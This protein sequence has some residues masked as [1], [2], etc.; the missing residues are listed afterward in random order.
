MTNNTDRSEQMGSTAKEVARDRLLIELSRHLTR[1]G[2]PHVGLRLS[3]AADTLEALSTPSSPPAQAAPVSGEGVTD[4]QLR[5]ILDT[6]LHSEGAINRAIVDGDD[7]VFVAYD[8]AIAAMR[9]ML[10][11]PP[12][13]ASQV[14]ESKGLPML[15]Y[16]PECGLQ[17]IDEP[18]E[19]TPEWDNP[20]HRSHLCHGCG[21]IWRPADIPTEGVLNLATSGQAD[22]W[23]PTKFAS[24]AGPLA[25]SAS[26]VEVTTMLKA[27]QWLHDNGF[28]WAASALRGHIRASL[29]AEPSNK[30]KRHG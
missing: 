29:Q 22:T 10:A 21:C 16:C 6:M 3:R 9:K 8:D 12:A 17:H 1:S 24:L 11:T 19:R 7:C 26:Q 20:P 30:D 14:A 25:A 2:L 27:S 28:V 5:L 18:D 15:L 4:S 23:A 13:S